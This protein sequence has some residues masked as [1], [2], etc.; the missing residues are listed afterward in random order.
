MREKD[1]APA[2][3]NSDAVYAIYLEFLDRK[4]DPNKQAEI[5]INTL[6]DIA[7]E[8]ECE[9]SDVFDVLT[10]NE[11]I[12]YLRQRRLSPWVLLNSKKFQQFFINKVSPEERIIMESII[13]PH[14]WGQKFES[15]PDARE[16]MRTYVSE[17]NL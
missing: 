15:R 7:E 1:I 3:W 12:H 5:T 16:L 17:L 6:F 13:R 14:Y 10:P 9:V 11:V 4:G 2:I 8:H